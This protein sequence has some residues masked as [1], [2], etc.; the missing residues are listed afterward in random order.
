MTHRLCI[1]HHFCTSLYVYAIVR[2]TR[3]SVSLALLI[4]LFEELINLQRL[5]PP[6]LPPSFHGTLLVLLLFF[7]PHTATD[8]ADDI[9]EGFIGKVCDIASGR[10]EV[11]RGRDTMSRPCCFICT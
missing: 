1:R 11:R 7:A 5:A 3:P 6:L 2:Q 9:V 4:S 10:A 8:D